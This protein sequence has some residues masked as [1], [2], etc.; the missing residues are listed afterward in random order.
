MDNNQGNAINWTR[1]L[2]ERFKKAYKEAND[3][4]AE[5]F[6]FDGHG[7]LVGYAKYLIEFLDGDLS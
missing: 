3:R 2:L 1:P 7:F 6:V 4:N 5:T